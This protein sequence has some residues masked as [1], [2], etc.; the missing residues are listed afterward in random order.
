MNCILFFCIILNFS[1]KIEAYNISEIATYSGNKA[2]L[3]LE[4]DKYEM[5][6]IMFIKEEDFIEL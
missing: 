6:E 2:D 1:P 5:S 4:S 3:Y